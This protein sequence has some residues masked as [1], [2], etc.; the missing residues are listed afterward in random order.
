[1][2]FNPTE[3][4]KAL[5]KA[6]ITTG[7]NNPD[8]WISTG[9]AAL[10]FAIADRFNVGIPNRR[11]LVYWGPSGAGKSLLAC[12]AAAEAQKQGYFVI[13]FDT[14][15]SAEDDYLDK[16]GI[17][18]T[19]DKLLVIR[20]STVEEAT[21]AFSEILSTT[22]PEDKIFFVFDSLS[23]LETEKEA[24]AFEKG[25]TS[26]DMG[27]FA[28]KLKQFMKNVN[29]KIAQRDCFFVGVAHCYENQDMLNGKGRYI[30]SGGGG[31]IYIPSITVLLTK[32]ELKDGERN[33]LGVKINGKVTKSRF[34]KLGTNVELEVPY[35]KGVVFHDGLLELGVEHGLIKQNGAWYSY[36]APGKE[37][38]FQSKNF[39]EH[40][41][42]IFQ[43]DTDFGAP[44]EGPEVEVDT[45]E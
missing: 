2:A 44:V 34:A 25:D 8:K 10:N 24:V 40:Y 17:E 20:V 27:L 21:K 36:G 7:I 23:N 12:K 26:N 5:T 35:D 28:K 33:V 15:E 18:R 45:E 37:V 13:Y 31:F 32:K 19:P 29:N 14:E 30:I 41:R 11:S 6:K 39:E 42:N 9:N 22:S 3:L 43:L 16:V 1:M 4:T 38:K